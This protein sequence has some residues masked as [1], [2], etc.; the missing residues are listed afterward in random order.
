METTLKQAIIAPDATGEK[1]NF[2]LYYKKKFYN[3]NIININI[4]AHV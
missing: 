1:L 3:H 4:C 2:F